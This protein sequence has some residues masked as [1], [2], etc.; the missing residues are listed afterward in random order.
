LDTVNV[1]VIADS[2]GA[3]RR[4]EDDLTA[5]SSGAVTVVG[6]ADDRRAAVELVRRLRPDVALV[7][8]AA[9]EPSKSP[10]GLATIRDLPGVAPLTRILAVADGADAETAVTALTAGAHGFVVRPDDPKDLVAPVLA[11]ACGHAVVHGPILSA[12][13]GSAK[14]PSRELPGAFNPQYTE[15][16]RMVADGLETT[17]IAE[18]LYV[19]ERTAK[20]MVAFLLRRLQVAN[21]IQAAALAGQVGLLDHVPTPVDG[22]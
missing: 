11:A 20:R 19:S 16:W 5:G 7:N 12:L 21:R 1:A 6:R 13:V 17:Q 4:L 22:T 2:D 9:G 14:P 15:L 3:A 10:P 18:R 8:L